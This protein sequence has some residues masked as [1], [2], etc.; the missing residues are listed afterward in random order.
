MSWFPPGPA[1]LAKA[2]VPELRGVYAGSCNGIGCRV[3]VGDALGS[4]NVRAY[5]LLERAPGKGEGGSGVRPL[6]VPTGALTQQTANR[7][8]D[9]L[10]HSND[11]SDESH[12]CRQDGIPLVA[13]HA[14]PP[15]M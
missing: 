14:S 8:D 13:P 12:S 5:A 15:S 4:R 3:V 7:C 11:R 1:Q 2:I 6:Y 9:V 10:E